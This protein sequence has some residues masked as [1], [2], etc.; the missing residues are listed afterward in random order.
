VA[1]SVFALACRHHETLASK[2]EIF[3]SLAKQTTQATILYPKMSTLIALVLQVVY[4]IGQP[5]TS[6]HALTTLGSALALV[7][8]FHLIRMDE[9]PLRPA[10]RWMQK[11][12]DWVEEEGR[13]RVTLMVLCLTR[14]LA[15]I[16]E[17]EFGIP[18]KCEI[19]LFLPVS[20]EVWF[21]GV[22]AYFHHSLAVAC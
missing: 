11:P 9:E 4:E 19:K 22:R 12:K 2:S 21:R 3:Y 18:L 14:W 1:L 20:D 8:A 5:N 7:S 15:A 13:R 6:L 10:T 17:R 16:Q